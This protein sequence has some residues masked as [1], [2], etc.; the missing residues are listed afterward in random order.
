MEK[1]KGERMDGGKRV[2]EGKY[3][4]MKSNDG[5]NER[6]KEKMQERWDCVCRLY[7]LLLYELNRSS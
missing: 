4:E 5:W 2:N 3:Q 6:V 7:E 1:N